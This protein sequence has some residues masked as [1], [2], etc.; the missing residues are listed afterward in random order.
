MAKLAIALIED[1]LT[2]NTLGIDLYP[3]A[4]RSG[5]DMGSPIALV[6]CNNFYASCAFSTVLRR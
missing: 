5:I 4:Y 3:G 6:D 1:H 2:W